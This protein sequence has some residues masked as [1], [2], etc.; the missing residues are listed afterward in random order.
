MSWSLKY[1]SPTMSAMSCVMTLKRTV[2]CI[3]DTL[4]T[5]GHH[6]HPMFLEYTHDEYCDMLLTG[7]SCNT[8][9][10]NTCYVIPVNTVQTLTCS[11]EWISVFTMGSVTPIALV[12]TGYLQTIQTPVNEHDFH[13][14]TKSQGKA[15]VI[16]R[17]NW[18]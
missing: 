13:M 9:A 6:F 15:H 8:D 3:Q 17:E 16:S 1:V 14:S 12:N 11:G 7:T 5:A 2:R 10:Q 4:C 18:V